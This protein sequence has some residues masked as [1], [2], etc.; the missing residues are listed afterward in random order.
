VGPGRLGRARV[1]EDLLRLHQRVHGSL[2]V[3]VLRLRAEPAVLG[4]AAALRVHERAHVGRLPEAVVPHQP[5]DVDEPLDVGVVRQLTELE[6]LFERDQG[7]HPGA[8]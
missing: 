4:A 7:R 8:M 1:L 3:R 6:R 2:G 5:G